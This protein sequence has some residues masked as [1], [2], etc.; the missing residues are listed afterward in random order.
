M[1]FESAAAAK[2]KM[3]C[4]A[5]DLPREGSHIRKVYDLFMANKGIPIN[6]IHHT[7][8]GGRPVETLRDTY[9]LDIRCIAP[10][11]WFLLAN[12]LALNIEITL[13]KLSTLARRG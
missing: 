6:F 3:T 7:P 13:P 2:G 4:P 9:G 1:H 8:Y 11:R 5:Q 10:G 12:G